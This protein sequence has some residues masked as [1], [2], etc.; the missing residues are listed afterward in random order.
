MAALLLLATLGNTTSANAPYSERLVFP[1]HPLHN[2]ASC[3][4]ECPN[5]DLLVCWYRGSGERTA[6]DVAIMGSRLRRGR[7]AWT[8]EFVLADTPGFPDC[9]PCMVVDARKRLWLFWPVI[10]DNKWDSALLLYKVSTDYE[11]QAGSPHW[12]DGG[13]VLLKPG[14]EFTQRVEAD[15]ERTWRQVADV[16][17]PEERSRLEDYL[18]DRVKAAGD[19]LRMRLGWMPRPHPVLLSENRLILPLYSDLFD[20]SLMAYSDDDGTS[21]KVS[22]P[23]IGAGNVQPTIAQCKDGTLVA[24]FRDNGP[25][26][27]R[28]MVSESKDRGSTWSTPR[29]TQ[30]PDPGAGVDVLV[31]HSGRWLLINNDTEEGRHSLAISISE[32]EGRTW[33][34]KCHLQHDEPGPDAGSYAYPSIIQTRDGRIHVTYS[35]SPNAADRA[36]LGGQGKSIKHVAFTE[37]WLLAHSTPLQARGR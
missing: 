34:R 20:F 16:V 35:Y 28:V 36:R 37:E 2:H 11:R 4:V 15:F 26:P 5:G 21:W 8:P 33:S 12:T 6:D 22:E 18:S 14:P 31:L 30:L 23:I 32:D 10:L 29:D 3:V 17:P 7:D 13:V 25:P 1:L 27:Q 9:N 19:K 24:Y